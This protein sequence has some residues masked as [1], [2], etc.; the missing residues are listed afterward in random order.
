MTDSDTIPLR[1]G[2]VRHERSMLS[3]TMVFWR[4]GGADEKP[5]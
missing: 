1:D 4:D 2:D 3:C 5:R